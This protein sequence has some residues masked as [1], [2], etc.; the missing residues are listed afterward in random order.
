MIQNI[1]N[2]I[3]AKGFFGASCA[4]INKLNCIF[5]HR[6]LKQDLIK[7]KIHDYNM[8]LPIDKV[9]GKG[10]GSALA[11]Y[12]IREEDQFFI[13]KNNIKKDIRILDIGGNIGYYALLLASLAGDKCKIFAV[14]PSGDNIELLKKNVELNGKSDIIDVYHM[15]MGNQEGTQ[16]LFLSQYSNLHGFFDETKMLR[17]EN[18]TENVEMK[19]IDSFTKDKLPIDFIRMDVEGFEVKVFQGMHEFVENSTN[20]IGILFEVHRSRYDNDEFNMRKEL[21]YLLDQGFIP[22]ALSAKPLLDEKPWGKD[23]FSKR[24]YTPDR[25][26]KEIGFERGYYTNLKNEDVLDYVCEIGCVRALFLNRPAR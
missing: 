10:I 21:S 25:V 13:L 24:G 18:H 17:E 6:I 20:E 2:L 1:I 22:E 23:V 14:E 15:G 7:R 16:Q 8:F 9:R 11:I 19:S 5:H 3:K 12:G 4:I 26:I